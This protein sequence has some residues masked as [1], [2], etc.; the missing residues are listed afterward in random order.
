MHRP[1]RFLRILGAAAALFGVGGAAAQPVV[2][3]AGQHSG[4]QTPAVPV[5]G[6]NEATIARS[7]AR[8]YFS[9]MREPIWVGYPRQSRSSAGFPFRAKRQHRW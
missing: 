9:G 1:S 4:K 3:P 6:H 8:Q 7:L 2:A 5:A